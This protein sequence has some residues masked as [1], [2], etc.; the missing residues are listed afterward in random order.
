[1]SR[2]I[3]L[4]EELARERYEHQELS[5]ATSADLGWNAAPT[6]TGGITGET[7]NMRSDVEMQL[8]LML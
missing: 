8:P 5:M 6:S 3:N 7:L 1:L 4:P 2:G